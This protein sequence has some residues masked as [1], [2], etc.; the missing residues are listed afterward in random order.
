MGLIRLFMDN[1]LFFSFDSA[2]NPK[3]YN[4]QSMK[5]SEEVNTLSRLSISFLFTHPLFSK[6]VPRKSTF[7]LTDDDKCLFIGKVL[8]MSRSMSND[9]SIDLE[10]LLGFLRDIVRPGSEYSSIAGSSSYKPYEDDFWYEETGETYSSVFY[11]VNDLL[12]QANYNSLYTVPDGKALSYWVDPD[13][14]LPNEDIPIRQVDGTY[15]GED[16]LSRENASEIA[17]FKNWLSVLY[18]DVNSHAGGV[19]TTEIRGTLSGV[20]TQ[21]VKYTISKYFVWYHLKPML[22]NLVRDSFGALSNP[23]YGDSPEFE[24]GSNILDFELEPAVNDPTT[25]IVPSGTYKPSGIDETRLVMLDASYDGDYAVVHNKAVL[26]YGRIE[27]N[28]D[29]GHL[30]G[31]YSSYSQA[32]AELKR[33][34]TD[35]VEERLGAF[36]D[37]I[38]LTGIDPYYMGRSQNRIRLLSLSHVV[39]SPHNIDLY[40]YCLSYEVDFFNHDRDRYIIGPFVPSNYFDYKASNAKQNAIGVTRILGVFSKR[41]TGGLYVDSSFVTDSQRV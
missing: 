17:A 6:I 31:E 38:T 22:A 28:L 30:E 14:G 13:T 24:Y 18:D 3:D 35:Y 34:C 5:L 41:E 11:S 20:G 15:G 26:K 36:G 19:I 8:T 23:S 9:V 10:D 25:A 2:E 1:E 32:R 29:F 40:D 7:I 37:R 12:K 21:A 39:S 27:K 33:I 16:E 4:L